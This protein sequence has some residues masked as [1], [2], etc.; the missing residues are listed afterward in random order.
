MRQY[1]PNTPILLVGTKSDLRNDTNKDLVS[2]KEGHEL[3]KE[4][5]FVKFM[6]CSALTQTNLKN[7][8][9]EAIK[10]AVKHQNKRKSN[11]N[12]NKNN[13]IIL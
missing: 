10:A 1:Q 4:L 3:A 7:L 5:N 9:N 12:K 13:C 6:E 11:E 8:F 2:P